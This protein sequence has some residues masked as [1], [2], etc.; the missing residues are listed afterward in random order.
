MANLLSQFAAAVPVTR[1]ECEAAGTPPRHLYIFSFRYLKRVVKTHHS[2]CSAGF[3]AR[4][5]LGAWKH[6]PGIESAAPK[7]V[8]ARKRH[9]VSKP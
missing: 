8:S 7:V 4:M 6:P 5:Q 1:I 3:S 2:C 9:M